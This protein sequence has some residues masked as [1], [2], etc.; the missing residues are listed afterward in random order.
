MDYHEVR[1]GRIAVF[2]DT[3]RRIEENTALQPKGRCTVYKRTYALTEPSPGYET[4][5]EVVNDDCLNA[6]RSLLKYTGRVAV[7]NMASH[8]TPGGGVKSGSGAQEENLC[9]RSNLYL[10]L[11][12]DPA[13]YPMKAGSF[14][15]QVCVFKEGEPDYQ[16]CT[17]YYVDVVSAAAWSHPEVVNGRLTPD[18]EEFTRNVMRNIFRMCALAG[19]EYLVLSALGCGAFRNPPAHIAQL[20]KETLE[21]DEFKGR[22]RKIVFAII[23]DHNSKDNYKTFALCLGRND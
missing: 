9:R 12:A 23:D 21:E 17:P 20:F 19:D 3:L 8:T 11:T 7:L 5:I 22:F 18:K 6:A 14:S 16:L 1:T 4:E 10:Y 13:A 15:E 2:R